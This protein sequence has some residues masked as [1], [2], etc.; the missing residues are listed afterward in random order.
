MGITVIQDSNNMKYFCL[1]AL[2]PLVASEAGVPFTAFSHVGHAQVVAHAPVVAHAVHHAAPAY[3][4]A[5]IVHAA[6][7]YHAAPVVHHAAPAYHAAPVVHHAAPVYHAAP[8]VHHAA[9]VYQEPKYNCSVVD[10][11]ESAEV[12]TPAFE[13]VCEN[14][15]VPVKR[16][17]DVEQCYPVTRT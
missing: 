14:I 4:A 5:P 12:C 7:A 11:V 9:P 16:I 8:V 15:E 13:T 17:I 6:P 3:A 10:V 2:V 1:F